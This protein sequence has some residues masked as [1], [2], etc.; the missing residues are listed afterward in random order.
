MGTNVKQPVLLVDLVQD[1]PTS[2]IVLTKGPVMQSQ[3]PASVQM[4]GLVQSVKQCK[5]QLVLE[6]VTSP[7]QSTTASHI[8]IPDMVSITDQGSDIS[9]KNLSHHNISTTS[10]SLQNNNLDNVISF[11][12]NEADD[13]D[14]ERDI[15]FGKSEIS[16]VTSETISRDPYT[17]SSHVDGIV[18]SFSG[19]DNLD[20]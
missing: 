11:D 13:D 5:S 9:D 17:S 7:G 20:V 4:A 8:N 6:E 19:S 2:V 14:N 16:M 10:P 1:V 15:V 18:D 12:F 3:E